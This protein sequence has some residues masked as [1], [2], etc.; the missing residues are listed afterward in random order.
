MPG[1]EYP[2]VPPRDRRPDQGRRRRH[3][4]VGGG[5]AGRGR[6]VRRQLR[7]LR[8]VPPRRHDRCVN[9]LV[10]GIAYDGGYADHVVVPKAALAS[11]PDDLSAEDAAPLLCAG[12]TTFNAL[13]ERRATRATWSPCSASVASATSGSSSPGAWASRPSRSPAAPTRRSRPAPRH[14]PLRRLHRHRRRRS[15]AGPW[16]RGDDPGHGDRPRRDERRLSAGCAPAAGWS[17]SAGRQTPCRSR[18]S[19]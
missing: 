7:L 14:P 4:P 5:P 16:R 13:R 11:I 9:G 1:I 18:R 6:L 8:P 2:R 10:P 17:S 3:V 19:R 15:P 12:I